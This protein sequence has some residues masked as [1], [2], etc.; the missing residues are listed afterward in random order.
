MVLPLLVVFPVLVV[1][2]E[3]SRQPLEVGWPCHCWLGSVEAGYSLVQLLLAHCLVSLVLAMG[4]IAGNTGTTE[5]VGPMDPTL[6]W[7]HSRHRYPIPW[8]RHMGTSM[9]HP[10]WVCS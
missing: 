2:A 4:A 5:G 7:W 8:H 6:C 3:V 9:L 1:D 10:E